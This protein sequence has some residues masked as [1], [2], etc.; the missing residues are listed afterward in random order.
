MTLFLRRPA[1]APN[2]AFRGL[3]CA[4]LSG[5]MATVGLPSLSAHAEPP[6]PHRAC[7]FGYCS[8]IYDCPP[9]WSESNISGTYLA[10][11]YRFTCTSIISNY[12]SGSGLISAPAV[13][14][15]SGPA[16]INVSYAISTTMLASCPPMVTGSAG[17][18]LPPPL[19]QPAISDAS[20]V[21]APDGYSISYNCSY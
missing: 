18:S 12:S 17:E 10:H 14:G 4:G 5:L 8:N 13:I 16:Q 6:T 20:I 2:L 19:P 9:A 3:I 21:A 11:G 1:H 15:P 7:A